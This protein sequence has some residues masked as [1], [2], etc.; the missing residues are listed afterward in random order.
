[1]AKYK[2]SDGRI[3]HVPDGDMAYQTFQKK[4]KQKNLT[5]ELITEEPES[6]TPGK[7]EGPT[8]E[9]V[10]EAAATVTPPVGQ[11]QEAD[12]SPNN[13]QNNTGS[14]SEDTSLE[15]Q[16]KGTVEVPVLNPE[17]IDKQKREEAIE[18]LSG[19]FGT[20]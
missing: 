7:Q 6:I 14:E 18:K 5:A 12:Q 17:E 10:V 15:S 11:N 19:I 4:L 2:L 3:V 13:Q 9:A 8:S 20:C 1:M 16:S